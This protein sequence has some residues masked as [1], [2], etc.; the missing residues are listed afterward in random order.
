MAYNCT[1]TLQTL[2]D[3]I[4]S[5]SSGQTVMVRVG[6]EQVQYSRGN[7]AALVRLYRLHW[8]DCGADAGLPKIDDSQMVRRGPPAGGVF[9]G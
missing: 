8:N 6:D 1:E 4:V 5:V 2:Y 7:Y 9:V 3:A